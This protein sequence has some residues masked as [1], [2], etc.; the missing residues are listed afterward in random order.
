MSKANITI[1]DNISGEIRRR[2]M[3]QD[4]LCDLL[5]VDRR[6]Y[7]NWQTKGE[8]PATKLL[9][10]ASILNCSVDYLARDVNVN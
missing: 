6:T 1:L 2:G 7:T 3:T 8:M 10:C 5:G 4:N 9:K